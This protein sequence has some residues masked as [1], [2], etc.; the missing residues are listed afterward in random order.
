MI[1]SGVKLEVR[2]PRDPFRDPCASTNGKLQRQAIIVTSRSSRP[3]RKMRQRPRSKKFLKANP[4]CSE[5]GCKSTGK[6]ENGELRVLVAKEPTGAICTV[7]DD[8]WVEIEV[9]IDSGATETVMAEATLNGIVDITEGPALRRGVTY[10]VANGVEIPNLGERKFVGFT[11]EG[12]QRGITA[13]V[14]AVNQPS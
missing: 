13:Q 8:E 6:N 10:E 1:Q 3:L 4:C 5:E 12:G 14:C 7:A 2:G 11:E 9:A